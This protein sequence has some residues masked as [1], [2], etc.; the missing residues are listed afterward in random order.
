MWGPR[1]TIAEIRVKGVVGPLVRG[2]WPGCTVV[3]A[4]TVSVIRGRFR[5][6][7]NLASV[8]A[9]L[10][11]QG[12][13]TIDAWVITPALGGAPDGQGS[14]PCGSVRSDGWTN[15]PV[16]NGSPSPGTT[17]RHDRRPPA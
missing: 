15:G 1:M 12:L 11:R 9:V 7:E 5:P 6:G 4:P 2:G 13:S 14:P 17:P 16:I 8:L 10:T 3:A